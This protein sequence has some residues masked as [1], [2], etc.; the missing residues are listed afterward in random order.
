[1]L[2]LEPNDANS[3]APHWL[4]QPLAIVG[5]ACRLPGADGL[6]EFWELL[7]SGG[8]AIERMPDAKLNRKRYFASQKGQRGKTYSDI[9]GFVTERDWDWSVLPIEPSQAKDWDECHLN[10][11][12]VAARACVHAGYDPRNLPTRN[13]GVFVGHSGGSTLG[14]E[15][16]L[17]T[18]AEDYVGL[19]DELASARSIPGFEGLQKELLTKMQ[20]GRPERQDGKPYVDA[21]YASGIISRTLGLTGP[22]MSIDAACASSLVALA[23]GANALQSGQVDMAIIGGASYNKADSLILFSHAQSCSAQGSRPFDQEA[24]GLIGSEGYVSVIVKTMQRAIDDGDQI[25]GVIRGIGMSSDGRGRSLWAP[26]KEGQF[27]AIQRAYSAEVRPDSVQMVEAHAT[28]TQVGDATEMEALAQ[29]YSQH[30]PAGVKLPIGSVKSNIGHTLET[31]GLAGLVKT[32][33][34]MQN[35]TIPPTVNVLKPS[36]SIPWQDIPFRLADQ[37]QSWPENHN[38]PRRAAVNAFGIG[39][40]NVHLVVDEYPPPTELKA[41]VLGTK[42]AFEPV[43]IIGRGMVIPGSLSVEAFRDFLLNPSSQL[44]DVPWDRMHAGSGLP[45]CGFIRDFHYDWRKHKI[46]PKQIDQANPLQFML[47][48]SAEQALREAG[49]LDRE[50]D[51]KRTAVVV[52]SPFGGDFGNALFAGLRLPEFREHLLGCLVEKG[53]KSA[54][55]QSLVQQYEQVF[56]A[57]NPALLDETGSFTS[58]TLAS[59]LTKTFDLMGG[60]MAIDASDTSG[61]ASLWVACGLLQGRTASHVLC[62]AAHRALD[63]AALC[64]M[65]QLGRLAHRDGSEQGYPVGE[66]V[67]LLLLK[68]KS[69]ALREGD[70]IFGTID[71][72]GAGFDAHNVTEAMSIAGQKLSTGLGSSNPKPARCIGKLGIAEVDEASSRLAKAHDCELVESQNLRS[73]GYL[74]ATQGLADVIATTFDE[75]TP[76]QWIASQTV[77]GQSILVA[78]GQPGTI[79]PPANLTSDRGQTQIFRFEARGLSE[80]ELQLGSGLETAS[81]GHFRDTQSWRAAIVCTAEALPAKAQ[82]LLKQL[83]NQ[84]AIQ[85]LQEQGLF[86]SDPAS[87]GRSSA[88]V[89]WLFPGQGSQYTGMLRELVQSDSHA[90]IAF[91]EANSQLSKIGLPTF[92]RLAWSDGNALGEDIFETQVAMLVADFVAYQALASRTRHADL[93]VGHSY[94][95]F[96]ALV[97]AGCLTLESAMLATSHRCQSIVSSAK[98]P[99]ALLSIQTSRSLVEGELA[100]AG[101]RLSI[102]HINSPE[103]IVVGGE[104]AAVE[105]FAEILQSNRI[106]CQQLSVPAAFHTPMLRAASEPFLKALQTISFKLPQTRILSSV[107]NRY[108]ADPQDIRDAL[109][110]QLYTPLDFVGLVRRLEEDGITLAIEV[111]PQQTLSKLARQ[112]ASSIRFCATDHP[113]RGAVAQL[114]CA[115][116]LTEMLGD[117]DRPSEHSKQSLSSD[118]PVA[119]TTV[120]FDATQTRRSRLRQQASQPSGGFART[121]ASVNSSPVASVHFDATTP[122]ASFAHTPQMPANSQSVEASPQAAEDSVLA[123]GAADTSSIEKFLVDFVVE[124]TGYPAEIIEL[125]WDIEADLGIDSIKKAQLFGELREFFDLEVHAGLSL[126]TF[127]SLRDIVHLLEKTPGKG[128]WLTDLPRDEPVLLEDASEPVSPVNVASGS[129]TPLK[130]NMAT[131][132]ETELKQILIDFVVEQT[133]YPAE[134]VELDADLE[135]DLGIDSIKKAQL[136]GELREMFDLG[137]SLADEATAKTSQLV[138]F[139]T[140]RQLLDILLASQA[141]PVSVGANASVGSLDRNSQAASES[142][143]ETVAPQEARAG[144]GGSQSMPASTVSSQVSLPQCEYTSEGTAKTDAAFQWAAQQNIAALAGRRHEADLLAAAEPSNGHAGWYTQRQLAISKACDVSQTSVGALDRALQLQA[145]WHRHRTIA[146]KEDSSQVVWLYEL[147]VPKWL[148]TRNASRLAVESREVDGV[149]LEQLLVPGTVASTAVIRNRTLLVVAGLASEAVTETQ[150]LLSLSSWVGRISDSSPES[151]RAF[152]RELKQ[153]FDWWV[154]VVDLEQMT[155][156]TVEFLD[157]ALVIE[158]RSLSTSHGST[159]N[160]ASASD[161]SSVWGARLGVDL[162]RMEFTVLADRGSVLETAEQHSFKRLAKSSKAFARDSISLAGSSETVSE[163]SEP[164]AEAAALPSRVHDHEIAS[165]YVLR[166]VP[167]PLKTVVGRQP[168][169]VGAA[170]IIGDNPVAVQLESRLRSVGVE[171]FRLAPSI[172]PEAL[173]EQFSELIKTKVIAHLFL[174]TPLD[175]DAKTTLDQ[176]HWEARRNQGILGNFW[177]CQRWLA[178]VA[179]LGIA[180][181]ASLV[182]T[183]SL[184]GEFGFNAPPT[185]IEGG[186]LSGLLKSMMIESWTQGIRPLPIKI[187]DCPSDSS[188]SEVV[189]QVW[190]ELAVPS[191]DFEVAYKGGLRHV[192]RA[193]PRKLGKPSKPIGRGGNWVCTGGA[194][195][196]TAYVAEELAT[197]YDLTLHL[198]GT[199]PE[200]EVPEHWRDLDA[201]RL[202]ALKAEVMTK[203]RGGAVNPVKAWQDVE[204]AIEIDATLRRLKGLGINAYYHSCD[205]SNRSAVEKTLA[206]VRALSGPIQGVLHGAGVGK[207]SRFDRKQKDKVEQCIAAKVDGALA[208]MESTAQDPIEYFVGFGSISGRFGANG[209]TDYSLANEMLCKQIDW[210]AAKRPEVTAIGFHWHAWGDVGMATKPETRLALE[211][212]DMQFM[213]ASEGI[214]HLVRELECGEGETEVLITDDRYYRMFFPAESLVS[215]ASTQAAKESTAQMPLLD[216]SIAPVCGGQS[217]FQVNLNPTRDPF[218]AEHLLDGKPLLP[219]VVACEMLLEAAQTQSGKN[220]SVL[221]DVEALGAVRFFHDA[222]QSLRIETQQVD[223]RQVACRLF[224]DFTAR[225]G[226]VV[227]TNRL[228]FQCSAIV[229]GASSAR[230]NIQLQLSESARWC[231]PAYPAV[232]AKFHV[233]WPLQRLRRFAMVEGGL[234]GRISA[235]ALIE[236]AGNDR[237]VTAWRIPSAAMDACLFATGILAWQKVAPG[238]ALPV[239]IGTLSIGRLPAPGEA[240]EVH[241]RLNSAGEGHASF[242]FTLYGVDGEMLLDAFDYKVAWIQASATEAKSSQLSSAQAAKPESH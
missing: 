188:P 49:I 215:A 88:K 216:R 124:Q 231:I 123:P 169:W 45:K 224:S 104:V 55:A 155:K 171:A 163:M 138:N 107:D 86:W 1:M 27:E 7:S 69:A 148:T 203:S 103:Q 221:S 95:E 26:R 191:Y 213:P 119:A 118:K 114:L 132:Q 71:G 242:D 91:Q 19:L 11:C 218:L 173:A 129:E 156:T 234:V 151:L 75:S 36:D 39:G 207:D 21:S 116:A 141:L 74:Q 140:L 23:L 192:I 65:M 131:A 193:I 110:K 62:A 130:A 187:I 46:P 210:Y 96:P 3:N 126:D 176:A 93:V 137:A 135:A 58:S 106:A 80:L 66:G 18:L 183:T 84:S 54:D 44:V 2:S 197:R 101:L 67:A 28:S 15:L 152:A 22:H 4:N 59:R 120:H 204:K 164:E 222:P 111:G 68:L 209:H 175:R 92:D 223:H 201:A 85:P 64:N 13:V 82:M 134:I 127:H 194:R 196:I 217:A 232:D 56:L 50:F 157:G 90:Q 83:G 189:G 236:L 43:A 198:L 41:K 94:G 149:T 57:A 8:Y 115:Q 47:L 73:T 98:T 117:V 225:D 205:V 227:D 63:R 40:L 167:A 60:A 220:V 31:A 202:R 125:D 199:A 153:P 34:A 211:M 182:A 174:T 24:D 165:R 48:E 32:V 78:T 38:A 89:A 214:E 42:P 113:K 105:K 179:E 33:L 139:T 177:L 5:M 145:G 76:G 206:E 17:R 143:P 35:E 195:G 61:L 99:S 237:N 87:R 185:S 172:D 233:G 52:G 212:I 147:R 240:C 159:Q 51:R 79:S 184:G 133:G 200:P 102:S 228:N 238:S 160:K 12:E 158:S 109:A 112:S 190:Q 70:K 219:F 235:P 229:D 77:G 161:L 142:E 128:N 154:D 144:Q 186:G 180:S 146:C 208:L 121:Q 14:G 108:K 37:C 81:R 25:Q 241:V 72:I 122:R 97:A 181:D 53:I 166:M 10:L 239:R 100:V 170:L 162:Q 150:S 136:F 20:A 30:L 29:F 168:Q 226:R 9:G 6:E 230:A 16:A 178:H